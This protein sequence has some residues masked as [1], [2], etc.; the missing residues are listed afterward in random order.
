MHNSNTSPLSSSGGGPAWP[1]GTDSPQ[2]PSRPA[3]PSNGDPSL[4]SLRQSRAS[5]ADAIS[6]DASAQASFQA[7][8]P[9]SM[10]PR[11]PA[12]P[13]SGPAAPSARS[14]GSWLARFVPLRAGAG[15]D[16][17]E[18][19][20]GRGASPRERTV[21]WRD[22]TLA[23][24]MVSAVTGRNMLVSGSVAAPAG[25]DEPRQVR[26][27]A[28]E[29]NVEQ[30]ANL[31]ALA[32]TTLGRQTYLGLARDEQDADGTS[33]AA[34]LASVPLAHLRPLLP[35]LA[36]LVSAEPGSVLAEAAAAAADGELSDSDS[37]S[38]IDAP[39]GFV[40]GR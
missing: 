23:S 20:S 39:T 15:P 31:R 29:A 16:P 11:H 30:D 17:H 13:S 35:A 7:V 38:D 1:A 3:S 14:T 10:R 27:S 24:R 18:S 19:S 34:M 22:E 37:D 36:G 21:R 8:S 40:E 25:Q 9:M 2:V 26:D 12:P 5:R 33:E 32:G 4:Q 6:A 28:L